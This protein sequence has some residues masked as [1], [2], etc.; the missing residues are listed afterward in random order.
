MHRSPSQRRFQPDFTTNGEM[1]M[2][3]YNHSI[4]SIQQSAYSDSYRSYTTPTLLTPYPDEDH[5]P[6]RAMSI[7]RSQRLTVE[8]QPSSPRHTS[9]PTAGMFRNL[10]WKASNKSAAG[11]LSPS[12]KPRSPL[13]VPG[14]FRSPST[15]LLTPQ[16][17]SGGRF[18]PGARG[19]DPIGFLA[20]LTP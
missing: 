17:P 19:R 1:N 4:P 14:A 7:N 13:H 16:T 10:F 6:S 8:P 12:A 2:G 18:S 15:G 3:G 5:R 9:S 11:S 20:P